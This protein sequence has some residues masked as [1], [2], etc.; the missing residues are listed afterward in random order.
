MKYPDF[1]KC[2]TR[3][4]IVAHKLHKIGFKP[5]LRYGLYYPRTPKEIWDERWRKSKSGIFTH[6]WVEVEE[7]LIDVSCAQFGEI[8]PT[9]TI[10]KDIRYEFLGNIHLKT[11]AKIPIRDNLNWDSYIIL[12]KLPTVY[13]EDII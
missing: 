5:I 1:S 6:S 8:V 3:S 4:F 13:M 2:G 7:I 10:L 11:G 9:I 12:N